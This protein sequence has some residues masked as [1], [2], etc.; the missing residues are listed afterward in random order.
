[1][2]L[3][4]RA[5]TAALDV[6]RGI[7]EAMEGRG[8]LRRGHADRVAQLACRAAAR[9]GLSAVE[10]RSL[11]TAARLHDIGE[12][13]IPEELLGRAGPLSEGEVEVVRSHAIVG[14]RLLE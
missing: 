9:L 14:A 7:L 2:R 4:R 5:E 3:R 6:A 11:E 12:I 13:G 1:E 8:P 10:R